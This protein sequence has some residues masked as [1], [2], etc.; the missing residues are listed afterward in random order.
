MSFY[1]NAKIRIKRS[2][3]QQEMMQKLLSGNKIF[4]A[5][6]D[7]LVISAVIGFVNGKYI[8]IEKQAS[9]G[10]LMQFF[11]ETDYDLMDLIAFSHAKEQAI[12]K[13]DEKYEIFSAYANGGFPILLDIL[14]VDSTTEIDVSKQEAIL[15][16]L[17]SIIMTNQIK[18]TPV[19]DVFFI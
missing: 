13:S 15:V 18:L 5:Y 3:D 12:L 2:A 19:E 16:K 17:T 14:G 6:R 8:P 4:D 11:T 1:T 9:D 7:I 10:V